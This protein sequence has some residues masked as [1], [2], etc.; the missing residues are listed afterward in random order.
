MSKKENKKIYGREELKKYFRNGN[1]PSENDFGFLIESMINKQDDGISKDEIDGLLIYKSELSK[2]LL[3]F[4]NHIDETQPFFLVERDDKKIPSLKFCACNKSEKADSEENSFF[5]H[6]GGKLGV[7][8]RSNENYKLDVKGF[9]GME[10]RIGTYKSGS[11]LADG[12]WHSVIKD[13]DNCQAFEIVARAGVKGKGKFAMMHAIALSTY[14]RS[15]SKIRKTRAH[16]G[17]FWNKLNLRWKGDSTHKYHLQL[18][19]NC[20]YGY[21]T[22]IFYSI[23]KLWD[24]ESMLPSG[25]S[26]PQ[27]AK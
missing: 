12:Q 1:I 10:G 6:E 4:F 15:R 17:F 16:Y 11:V 20:N 8:K 7:G 25:Y 5:F 21:D 14:G 13:L 24:D 3:T 18:R 22:R 2:R 27:K 26:Y 19:S 23:T 9:V